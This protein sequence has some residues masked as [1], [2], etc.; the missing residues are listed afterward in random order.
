MSTTKANE[1]VTSEAM[2][3]KEDKEVHDP[4]AGCGILGRYP[5]ISVISFATVG[6]CVGIGCVLA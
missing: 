5:I 6:I 4:L 1:P 2:T 3:S